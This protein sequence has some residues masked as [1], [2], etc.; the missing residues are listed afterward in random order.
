MQA[1]PFRYDNAFGGLGC[2]RG[3]VNDA[4]DHLL[5]EFQTRDAM[6][7]LPLGGI[8][9]VKVPVADL[10]SVELTAGLFGTGLGAKLVIRA[11]RLATLAGL[12]GMSQGRVDLGIDRHDLAAAEQFVARLHPVQSDAAPQPAPPT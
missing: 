7:G 6:F 11:D 1:V 12:P 10:A 4:G 8:R 3:L 9:T 5:F 2:C